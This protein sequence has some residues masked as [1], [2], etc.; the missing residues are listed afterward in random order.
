M[1]HIEIFKKLY[2]LNKE[3]A[4]IVEKQKSKHISEELFDIDLRISK[5]YD[6]LHNL[7]ENR[8]LITDRD[9]LNFYDSIYRHFKGKWYKVYTTTI[10]ANTGQVNVLYQ[11]LYGECLLYNRE[12]NEFFSFID[13]NKYPELLEDKD[14]IGYYR[15]ISM[16]EL[17]SAIGEEETKNLFASET[18]EE[19]VEDVLMPF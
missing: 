9:S 8:I 17:K 6:E 15:F 10:D 5:L 3:R 13:F 7:D 16:K 19:V 14:G 11:A 4:D 12:L 1:N 18:D 2:Q